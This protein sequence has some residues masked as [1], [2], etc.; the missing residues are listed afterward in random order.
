MKTVYTDEHRLHA[1]QAELSGGRFGPAF[2]IP[3]RADMVLARVRETKLGP[4]L[5]PTRH[6]PAPL[7]RVHDQAFV[8]FLEEAYEEWRKIHG[9]SEAIPVVWPGPGQRRLKPN[10]LGARM[11]YYAIDAS[12]P[13]TATTWR[14]VRAAA[15]VALTAAGLV[16]AG[17]AAAFALCRPPGHHAGADSYG[18]YCFLNNAAIAAQALRDSGA[19]RVAILDV[20][21]HHG[22]GTQAIFYGSADVLFASLHGHPEDEYPYFSGYTD[23]TGAGGGE[24]FNRNYPLRP[25]TAWDGYRPALADAITGIAAYGPDAVVVSLGVDTFKDDPISRFKLASEDYLRMGAMIAGLRRPTLFVM[26]GGYAVEAIGIN[27]VN[28]LTGFEQAG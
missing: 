15:D 14:A 10:R 9:E 20:D 11:G 17:E 16:Q 1:Q 28:A 22:N 4:V 18:G 2:E 7:L 13:L 25:G 27:A 12:T 26:E 23:E 21:F 6:G 24:G 8:Q 5:A 3:R 19:R